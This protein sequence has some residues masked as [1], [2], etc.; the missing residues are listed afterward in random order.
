MINFFLRK[1]KDED[2]VKKT[3]KAN[4]EKRVDALEHVVSSR[5][6]CVVDLL[7]R[8]KNGM[9]SGF[10]ISDKLIADIRECATRT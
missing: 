7:E 1:E 9:Y 2:V 10:G 4:L 6:E 5:S 8:L 3:E